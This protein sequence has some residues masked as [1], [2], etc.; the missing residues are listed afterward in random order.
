MRTTSDERLLA[1]DPDPI[2]QNGR[3]LAAGH[4]VKNKYRQ[5]RVLM[6]RFQ[7]SRRGL[8]NSYHMLADALREGQPIEPAALCLVDNF[9]VVEDQLREV[10][11]GLTKS[12]NFYLPQLPEDG[13]H[14]VT[15]IYAVARAVAGLNGNRVETQTLMRFLRAYQELAPISI[16]ELWVFGTMLRLALLE[17]LQTLAQAAMA[18]YDACVQ[19]EQFADEALAVAQQ[20]PS[21]LVPWFE[22]RF[23]MCQQLNH[24][25]VLRLVQRL[26][27]PL[28]PLTPALACLNRQLCLGGQ[29]VL[30]VVRQERQRQSEML[31]TAN[32][33]TE[34]MRLLSSIN[35]Q[36]FVESVSLLD[37]ILAE[38]PVGA[39][40]GMDF[41]TRNRYRQV[42]EE[43]SQYTHAG[44]LNVAKYAVVLAR[45]AHGHNDES[46]RRAHVGYYLIDDGLAQLEQ[47]FS[48]RLTL[49]K[50]LTRFMLKARTPIYLSSFVALTAFIVMLA[51][52]YAW[53]AGA[54][55]LSLIATVFLTLIPATVIALNVQDLC[56]T[57]VLKPRVLPRMDTSDGIPADAQTMVVVPT[58]LTSPES[59]REL[60]AKLEVNY[61]ANQ[62]E[63]MQFA[64]LGDFVDAGKETMPEDSAVLEAA[65]SGIKQLNAC[66]AADQPPRFHLF[67]R[68]RQW[69]PREE[70]W[71]GWE[72]KR[73]KLHEFNRLLRGARD[74]SFM[75]VADPQSLKK[76]RYVITLDSDT[77]LT[78]D[79][80]R[81]LVGFITH[82][83]NRPHFDSQAGRITRGYAVLQPRV[84]ISLGSA[85]RSWFAR[86][87]SGSKGIDP[88][89]TAGSDI[90]QDLF[91]EGIFTGKGLYDVDA[92]EAALALRV[93]ENSI[94]SH[95]LFE[96]LFARTS[97]VTEIQVL[98]DHPS[99]YGAY[100]RRQHRWARGDWQIARWIL[101]R[102][103]DASGVLQ[104]NTLPLIARWKILDNL[105]RTLI[106]P[107]TLLLLV[108]GWMLLP[109]SPLA[110]TMFA[111]LSLGFPVY[112]RLIPSLL[113]IPGSPNPSSQIRH[114]WEDLYTNTAQILFSI[115]VLPHQAYLMLNAI[116][117]T[118]YRKLISHRHLLDWVTAAQVERAG[119]NLR[120]AFLTMLWPALLIVTSM[121]AIMWL[122]RPGS[123]IVAVP[124]LLA[125]TISPLIAQWVSRP[126]PLRRRPL[127][128]EDTHYARRTARLTWR[129]FETFAGPDDNWLPPDN[130]QEDPQP[131]LAH[132]TSPTNI[133]LFLLSTLAAYDLGYL[134]F[135][136]L[137]QRLDLTFES[138]HKL[139]RYRGHYLN[140]YDTQTLQ[141]VAPHYISTVDSGNL[142]GHLIA[143]EQACLELAD[144][145][146][147]GAR[148]IDGLSDVVALLAEA[149][150]SR[151]PVVREEINSCARLL[152]GGAPATAGLWLSLFASLEHRA[153]KIRSLIPKIERDDLDELCF[154]T[155]ALEQSA[156]SLR[157]ELETFVP[158]IAPRTAELT[159]VIER[160]SKEAASSWRCLIGDL[161]R[162]PSASQLAGYCNLA[163]SRLA[164]LRVQ[165]EHSE[166][167]DPMDQ[168]RMLTGVNQLTRAFEVAAAQAG[169]LLSRLTHFAHTSKRLVDEMDLSF[170]YNEERNVFSIG[171]DISKD[172]TDD[173]FYDLLASEARLSS[174]VAIAKG[175]APQQHWFRLGRGLTSTRN[176]F[177]LVSWAATM[178][179]YLMPLLVMRSY[180]KTLLD[181][182]NRVALARHIEYAQ[183]QGIPWGMSE[184]SCF[185]R[186]I[187]DNY[188]YGTFGVPGLGIKRGLSE[189]LVVT[190]YASLLAVMVVP[191]AALENLR[192][193]EQEGALGRY[194]FYEAVDYTPGRLPLNS[195]HEIVR[196]F[197]AHHQGMSLLA[198]DNLLNNNVMQR[199]FHASPLV[200]ATELLL[201]ERI[202]CGVAPVRLRPEE[203]WAKRRVV[204]RR[205]AA[206]R[207]PGTDRFHKQEL[208]IPNGA[209]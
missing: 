48:C 177:V 61:L 60:L 39:Y 113:Q 33:L 96:G 38:D 135:S 47:A 11:D 126:V 97:L 122:A 184:S 88:Y 175:S 120:S 91:G 178:F 118:A 85:S 155:N 163:L 17:N 137:V 21:Q 209:Q 110:W 117:R 93:P 57:A 5:P 82:P 19:A 89:I 86:I 26:G 114:A 59:V 2:E 41:A 147:F 84:G 67:H 31:S 106:A 64:L 7:Q 56:M 14:N 6:A 27:E 154:W 52:V 12:I 22:K 65:I 167:Y 150:C 104:R 83:L 187:N 146:L 191:T 185:A 197:M 173:Y 66:Y 71:M 196:V 54:N 136:E 115:A 141:P 9:P 166:P 25:F 151:M 30:E 194:G 158:T 179:E 10:L 80:A 207:K 140:W 8:I 50:R 43:V 180:E 152:T 171:Y 176:G 124:F 73:G 100:A 133:G 4:K 63:F 77:Q 68:R 148:I 139:P 132:R 46:G 35:W 119:A 202:P 145:P 156:H 130:F 149:N 203:V 127:D 182:S 160:C 58:L 198:L 23:S 165:L 183:E 134:G 111:L 20:Q 112:A 37:V 108:A 15:R 87:F 125:W 28:S 36:D 53:S 109:G 116:T 99:S 95:D 13:S 157:L 40:V 199:R 128:A 55:S 49:G 94:L 42:V 1:V 181:E 32:N 16:R 74:T 44:E 3:E 78:R 186:D 123:T 161:D 29:N 192:R 107:V 170:L 72:R 79:A 174:F 76:I 69:N 204:R 142:A 75:F 103:P 92:F 205:T 70:K 144:Q 164:A 159:Q 153:A 168:E 105:R 193:L 34:S 189:D 143:V 200:R 51:V 18:E 131:V 45:Q 24:A 101:P 172:Q 138:L 90:Y 195:T 188:Q 208:Y 121:A 129:F 81:G 206:K 169:Q 201:Q 62:D 102:V 190:P 162:I 98:D